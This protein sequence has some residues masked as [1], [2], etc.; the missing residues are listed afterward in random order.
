MLSIRTIVRS[1]T[2]ALA[3]TLVAAPLTAHA[4]GR[5]Q[6]THRKDGKGGKAGKHEKH[7]PMKADEFKD[8][9]EKRI[10]H[11]RDRLD[12]MLKERNVPDAVKTQVKKDYEDGA[13][14]VRALAAKVQA[15]GT[16]T[17]EEAKQVRVL[18]KELKQKAREKYNLGKGKHGKDKQ[19]TDRTV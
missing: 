10:A 4:E 14:A 11:G 19:K 5:A 16:V 3:L 2:V 12:K 17:K 13:T 15:D 7:F 18:S 9:V 8:M 6:N 1:V